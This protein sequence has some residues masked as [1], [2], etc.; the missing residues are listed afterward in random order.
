MGNYSS[1]NTQHL[2]RLS[3]FIAI[4]LIQSWVPFLGYINIGVLSITYV[5]VTVILGTL[6]LGTRDG[7]ILGFVF[8]LNSLIRA[9]IIGGPVQ[10]LVFTS[11]LISVLP[12]MLMPLIVGILVHNIM[13]NSSPHR[14][15]FVAGL[16]GSL[17]NT[18]LVLGSIGLFKSTAYITAIEGTALTR[19]W[20][21]LG[22]I[23]LTNGIPEAI[24]AAFVT[25][26]IYIAVQKAVESNKS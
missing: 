16:T 24:F 15:G 9:W 14:K 25:P 7:V 1:Y 6:W 10:R 13:R 26:L 19:I 2:V 18:V 17:L 22:T 23:V 3:L 20:P 5:H 11:P 12:R 21:L 8:G 4:L